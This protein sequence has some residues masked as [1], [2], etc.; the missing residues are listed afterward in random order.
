MTTATASW[1]Q[2]I[3]G[4]RGSGP[5][6][7]R[8]RERDSEPKGRRRRGFAPAFLTTNNRQDSPF[9]PHTR[10]EDDLR[11]STVGSD[12]AGGL[13]AMISTEEPDECVKLR[14]LIIRLPASGSQEEAGQP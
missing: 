3:P 4:P 8:E 12:E 5:E 7:E 9:L 10:P 14:R 13:A 1:Q 6:R 2:G 11:K